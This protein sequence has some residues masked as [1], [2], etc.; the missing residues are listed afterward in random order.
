MTFGVIL[1]RTRLKTD[2]IHKYGMSSPHAIAAGPIATLV[3]L[4][5]ILTLNYIY[6]IVANRLTEWGKYCT[7]RIKVSLAVGLHLHR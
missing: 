6:V 7:V 4:V 2:L 1:L 3:N 5:T